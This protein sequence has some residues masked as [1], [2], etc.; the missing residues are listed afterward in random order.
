MKRTVPAVCLLGMFAVCTA[1]F[2]DEKKG[3]QAPLR[4][5]ERVVLACLGMI[6]SEKPEQVAKAER[7]LA[8]Q[9]DKDLLRPLAQAL[10]CNPPSLR[11]YAAGRLAKLDD[12]RAV[13][14]LL[15]KVVR[16]GQR[17]VRVA[18]VAALRRMGARDAVHVL[19]RALWSRDVR[20]ARNAAEALGGLGD[21]QAY[22]YLIKRWSA[23]SGNFPTSYFAQMQQ[24]QYLQDFDVEVA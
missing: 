5:G 16:E 21:T 14:P 11:I 12:A 13:R 19:G 1:G 18:M 20:I 15:H 3:A 10:S 2:A 17:D 22:P 6:G 4:Q 24:N 8:M 7:L 23:R 9:D